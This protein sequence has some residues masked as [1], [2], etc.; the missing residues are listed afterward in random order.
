MKRITILLLFFALFLFSGTT[1]L[2]ASDDISEYKSCTY[3]G[4]DRGKFSHS[5]M[6]IKYDDGSS[7]GLCSLHCAAIDLA[8]NIGKAPVEIKVSDF[9]TKE[10]MDAER[11][12]W[13]IGGD[14]QGVMTRRAKWAFAGKKDAE[15]F[16]SA[17]RGTVVTFEDALRA[18]Y[19]DMYEDTMMIRKKRK[20]MMMHKGGHSQGGMNTHGHNSHY[21]PDGGHNH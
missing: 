21:K 13:V 15:S 4:M 8:I 2:P 20:E 16:V 14:I 17:H 9:N 3:C 11:A 5:R 12:H 6:Y 10:L 19:E 18:A 1:V 7:V